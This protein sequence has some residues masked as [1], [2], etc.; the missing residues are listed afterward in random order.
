MKLHLEHLQQFGTTCQVL[1]QSHQSKLKAHTKSAIFTGLNPSPTGTWHY[2]APPY[3]A[4]QTLQN[5]FFP[6]ILPDP[7]NPS[8][9]L[10]LGTSTENKIKTDDWLTVSMPIEGEHVSTPGAPSTTQP[11][12]HQHIAP[13]QAPIASAV[14]MAPKATVVP[15]MPQMEVTDEQI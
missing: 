15:E 12:A 4:I 6:R 5:V 2:I 1:I 3:H 13:A 11:P 14:H 10:P 7:S 9:V 8:S